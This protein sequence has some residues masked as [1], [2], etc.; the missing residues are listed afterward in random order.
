[1]GED[2][3]LARAGA[4]DH[5]Q[6]ALAVA[7]GLALGLVQLGEQPLG[8]VGAGLG[9]RR[10]GKR[11]GAARRGVGLCLKGHPPSIARRSAGA[12]EKS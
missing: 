6:R 4:G 5:Q 9:R 11:G 1:M 3:G 8:A 7:D 10:I 2:A 12:Q